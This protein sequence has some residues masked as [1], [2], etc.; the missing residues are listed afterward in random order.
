MSEDTKDSWGGCIGCVGIILGLFVVYC[1]G[2][3]LWLYAP[4][5]FVAL[6]KLF[7]LS[8]D[9]P[10]VV[11]WA[12]WGFAVGAAIQGCREMKI[13]GRKGIGILIAISPVL[14]LVLVSTVKIKRDPLNH[15]K[16]NTAQRP[17]ESE[18][19]EGMV[20]IPAG[21]YK[22]RANPDGSPKATDYVGAFYID[23]YEVTNAEYVV[24]LNASGK[25]EDKRRRWF[26]LE[27]PEARIELVDGVYRVKAGYENH[28]ASRVS[29]YGAMA[30]AKWAQKRLPT[31][32]EWDR[33]ARGG[34]VGKTYRWGD[35]FNVTRANIA[36]E[37][38]DTTPVGSYAPNGYG[39]YDM[40]GNVSEWC[41]DG[42]NDIVAKSLL[43]HHLFF[44]DKISDVVNDFTS[45]D[46]YRA[47]LG[48]N[49]RSPTGLGYL[50]VSHPPSISDH[51]HPIGFRCVTTDPPAD[52]D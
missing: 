40:W 32:I 26:N 39:L 11:V 41:L 34:L 42:H 45:V 30:Y 2:F 29:W 44:D 22:L 51:Y 33:A 52:R 35:R 18:G 24:F 48:G 49:W 12:F 16:A 7:Y 10:V 46:T 31:N 17:S 27:D 13:Y 28:P 15:I 9:A 38:G 3:A 6:D 21:E 19:T 23:K 5:L 36:Y 47:L 43:D 1:I 50:M 25:H 37:V 8:F 20:L 4:A 14:L